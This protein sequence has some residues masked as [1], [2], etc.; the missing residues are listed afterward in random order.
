MNLLIYCGIKVNGSKEKPS[1]FLQVQLISVWLNRYNHCKLIK[2]TFFVPFTKNGIFRLTKCELSFKGLCI[3]R[4]VTRLW[5][6]RMIAAVTGTCIFGDAATFIKD[7][8]VLFGDIFIVPFLGSALGLT[9][10]C[11]LGWGNL[12]GF[13]WNDLPV[14]REFDC[15]FLKKVKSPPYA[16][17]PPP[18]GIT[19]IG[20]LCAD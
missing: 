12:V 10:M 2:L 16:L 15:K 7:C 17:P 14:G 5:L 3:L 4:S 11:S 8:R 19:L 9:A 20:A 1:R 18:A 6:K 13:D